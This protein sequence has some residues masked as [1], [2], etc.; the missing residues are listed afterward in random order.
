MFH[1]EHS[2]MYIQS[3][4]LLTDVPRGTLNND[5]SAT[6]AHTPSSTTKG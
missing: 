3:Y 2:F 1:V 5:K 6:N 4:L